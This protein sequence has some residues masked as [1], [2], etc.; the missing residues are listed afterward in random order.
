MIGGRGKSEMGGEE[1]RPNIESNESKEL[2]TKTA[3]NKRILGS[4]TN[5]RDLTCG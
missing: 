4:S 2:L 5:K 1:I 3:A